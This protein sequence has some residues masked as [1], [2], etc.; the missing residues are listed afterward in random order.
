MQSGSDYIL[1]AMNRKYTYTDYCEKI[2]HI[3]R[4]ISS[5]TI[6]TD[7]I[8]GFPGESESDFELTVRAVKEIEFDGMFAFKYSRRKGTKAYDLHGQVPD[9]VKAERLNRLLLVQEDIAL[10]RNRAMEGSVQEI[11][12][13]GPSATDPLMLMGRTRSNKIV[14]IGND[15]TPEGAVVRVCI[16]RARHHSLHATRLQ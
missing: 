13:E 14:T 3:R 8:I 5:V 10:R 12:I 6:T 11:L 9:A 1:Q 7:I 4:K 2:D 15:G 16:E